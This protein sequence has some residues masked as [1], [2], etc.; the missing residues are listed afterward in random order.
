MPA[1]ERAIEDVLSGT[2]EAFAVIVRE[3]Q[4][5]VL[6]L[7]TSTLAD[8]TQAEDAAQEIFIKAFKA[9]SSFKRHSSFSTWLYRIAANHCKDVLRSRAR[10]KTES[11]DRMIEERGEEAYDALGQTKAPGSGTDTVERVLS[12]LSPEERVL[13]AL[14]E[15]D[16]L[17]YLEIARTLDCSLD[18]VKARL[19]RARIALQETAKKLE[20]VP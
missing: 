2:T 20:E 5:K 1:E 9:L 11:L 3:Y 19:R 13:L 18:A 8:R 4:A 6:G 15:V 16:G 12:R 17:S 14:R 7:C 10:Q